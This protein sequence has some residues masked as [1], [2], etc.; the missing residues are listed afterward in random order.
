LSL[1]PSAHHG[2]FCFSCPPFPLLQYDVFR[3]LVPPYKFVSRVLG[4]FPVARGNCGC[5]HCVSLEIRLW[6]SE[7]KYLIPIFRKFSP[8]SICPL[9][10]RVRIFLSIYSRFRSESARVLVSGFLPLNRIFYRPL[11]D[12]GLFFA[13]PLTGHPEILPPPRKVTS[14]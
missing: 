10:P 2:I 4:L 8:L 14:S 12:D 5:P 1:F 6:F 11:Q 9:F 7:A 13:A 3:G